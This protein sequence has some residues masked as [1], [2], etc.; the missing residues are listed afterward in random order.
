MKDQI[1][2]VL[3]RRSPFAVLCARV[4][5]VE[6]LL[7][8]GC[9]NLDLRDG[10]YHGQKG[11]AW[12]NEHSSA[13]SFLRWKGE[14]FAAAR[15]FLAPNGSIYDFAST[16]MGARVEV[17]MREH[18]EVLS[19]IRWQKP[20]SVANRTEKEALRA[21]FP[22]S[23]TILFAEQ[24]PTWPAML[25]AARV[26]AGLS[27][28]DV[29]ERVLGSR[30]GACWNWEAGI[31]FPK[32][33][34]WEALRSL[35]PALPSYEVIARPYALSA[36]VPY[37]D[38]WTYETVGTYD[39]KH[40]CEKPRA[41]AADMIRA[42][43]RPGDLVLV[44]FAGSGIFAAEA[45][46]QG[47]RVIAVEADPYWAERTR[48]ACAI[49]AETGVADIKRAARTTPRSSKQGHPAQRSLFGEVG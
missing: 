10:P 23:E 19:N 9:I 28:Q 16:A 22:A 32:G 31:S 5:D 6:P 15:R 24:R 12:D 46:A 30:S 14:R 20:S 18:F 44:F 27:R 36:D 40:P 45:L 37:T 33:H 38:V 13:A 11:D 34:H 41:M 25:E 8:D 17:V 42:S 21:P 3:D 47:R 49:A 39:G 4:E 7:P 48:A 2:A 29:S 35:L 1:A 43:S 26:A